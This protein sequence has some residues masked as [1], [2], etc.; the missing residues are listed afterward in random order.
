MLSPR[1]LLNAGVVVLC[2][3]L[4]VGVIAASSAP[5]RAFG[6]QTTPT[7]V[8]PV[9]KSG[10]VT[11]GIQP[12]TSG[13]P[14]ARG[15][16]LY[17]AGV[18][19]HLTDYVA[20]TDYSYQPLTLTLESTDIVNTADGRL[21]LEGQLAAV[22]DV[23][24]WIRIPAVY[25]TIK[26]PARRYVIVPFTVLV[27][28]DATPGD[29]AGGILVTLASSVTS[30]SGQRLKLLQNVGVRMFVRVSGPLHPRLSINSLKADDTTTL[31]PIGNG[32]VTVTYDVRNTGNV[33]LGG[34]QSVWVTGL[35]GS[36]STAKSPPDIPLL[37]P[38]SSMKER[39]VVAGV[40]PEVSETAHVS[41]KPLVIPGTT[42]P[43]SGP[44][45]AQ[46]S[47][48]AIP[49]ILLAILAAIVLLVLAW[50]WRRR[51]RRLKPKNVSG[52]PGVGPAGDPEV[53]A[54]GTASSEGDATP[55]SSAATGNTTTDRDVRTEDGVEVPAGSSERVTSESGQGE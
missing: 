44:Y 2:T 51:R 9:G 4:V 18:S 8:V 7:T 11:F 6:Q 35:F 22:R 55:G 28:A 12:A 13:K 33:A 32:R 39:V 36:K 30:P 54:V 41:I 53:V 3:F 20:I 38:G 15:Y 26:V 52:S 16:F 29:H 1:R 14:D 45:T 5:R 19:S 43:P 40:F 23:G 37:L 10:E 31:N 49:W 17:G 47:F 48:L 27:P 42:M 50:F 21:S 46:T 24:Q 25:K 34:R